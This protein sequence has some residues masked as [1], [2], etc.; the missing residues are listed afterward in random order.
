[1]T[2]LKKIT[3]PSGLEALDNIKSLLK[4]DWVESFWK[5]DYE[6]IKKELGEKVILNSIIEEY[7]I[8]P[9]EIR[10]AFIVFQ[11]FRNEPCLKKARSF[12]IINEKGLP[13]GERDMILHSKDYEEYIIKFSWANF[14]N[15]SIQKTKEEFKLL[16]EVL[17]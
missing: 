3:I 8:K 14:K 10:E 11:M 17:K 2:E 4:D 9:S 12:E 15:I 5:T 1:M 7:D 6:V 16:K 13:L